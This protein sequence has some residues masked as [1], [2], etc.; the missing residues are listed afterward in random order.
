MCLESEMTSPSSYAY[1]CMHELQICAQLILQIQNEQTYQHNLD[2]QADSQAEF[3]G[4]IHRQIHR[5][6]HSLAISLDECSSCGG[7]GLR[8]L[9]VCIFLCD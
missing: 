8:L 1:I 3:T 9:A 2:S 5:Q 6:I 7:G 4:R